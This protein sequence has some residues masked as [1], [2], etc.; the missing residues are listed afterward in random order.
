MCKK[1]VIFMKYIRAC[2]V[3]K[4]YSP[5]C[6]WLCSLCWKAL[7]REY[8]SNS[9][10]PEKNLPHLRLMDWHEDNDLLIRHFINSLKQGGPDF[11]FKRM[12][13][14]MFSR[15]L[16]LNLW[17]KKTS[18]IFIP[19]PPKVK[20]A[21][22]HADQLASALSFYFKGE[23]KKPLKRGPASHSQKRKS[24]RQRT[25]ILI[26][27]EESLPHSHR[28]IVFVDDVL[29]TGSTARAT[30]QALNKPKNFFIFS[31]VWK[32]PPQNSQNLY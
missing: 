26:Q 8:L 21:R 2:A 3:C 32:R 31:L 14:E 30:F 19:A 27:K 23:I 12:G 10:R 17:S 7:E 9:Y 13:L 11:I 29:T 28:P 16:Y 20:N 5:P 18:A 4:T 15:F 22:D 6:H 25:E 24:K 1:D